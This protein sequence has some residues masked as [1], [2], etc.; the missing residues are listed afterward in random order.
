MRIV[1]AG[2]LSLLAAVFAFGASLDERAIAIPE[3]AAVP[4]IERYASREEYEAARADARFRLTRVTYDSDGLSVFAYVYAPAA[5]PVRPLPVVVFNRGSYTWKEFAGEYLTTFHRLASAG[6]VVIA[7]MLRGS[8]GAPGRDEMGGA[9]LD[10][11]LN[12]KT[13][14][15]QLPFADRNAVCMYGES[16]GAM[17]TYQAVR[18]HYPMRAAAVYGGFTR[19]AE[20]AA[21][22]GRFAGA[23]A[24]IWPDYAE[25]KEEIDR[26]RSAVE[27]PEQFA[28]PVLIMHGGADTDVAPSHALELAA[29]L[30]KLGKP[31]E[32]VIRSGANHVLT[33]WRKER[34]AHAIEWF[35]RHLAG[36]EPA[37]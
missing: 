24:A 33:Q 2:L 31:Y 22:G 5:R 36:A 23:A 13:L 21:P 30:Q 35:R 32:L 8:G 3:Y 15:E 34:D 4:K 29:R 37:R 18:E 10:D 27:W 11:L 9:E 28:V 7:P 25:R 19:L 1:V 17:M 16:R 12:T 20:L 6:F 14:L 26:R